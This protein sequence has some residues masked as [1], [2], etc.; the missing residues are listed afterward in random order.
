MA[1]VKLKNINVQTSNLTLN[2]IEK[3]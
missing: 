2:L 1:D 3:I